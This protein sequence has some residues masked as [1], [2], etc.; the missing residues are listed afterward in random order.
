MA[1]LTEE[2][3][4]NNK[5]V[6][7]KNT[8]RAPRRN[9]AAEREKVLGFCRVSIGVI[10]SLEGI[11]QSEVTAEVKQKLTG[12]REAFQDVLKLMNENGSGA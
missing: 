11:L 12:K 6:G 4:T 8:K 7:K 10:D 1:L 3:A 5:P 9:F 2:T